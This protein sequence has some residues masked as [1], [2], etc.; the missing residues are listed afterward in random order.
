MFIYAYLLFCNMASLAS[1][2]FALNV[3]GRRHKTELP[4]LRIGDRHN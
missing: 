4:H 1:L 2:L 3:Q